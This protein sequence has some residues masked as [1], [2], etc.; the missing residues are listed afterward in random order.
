MIKNVLNNN[1]FSSLLLSGF[2]SVIGLSIL[3]ISLQIYFDIDKIITKDSGLINNDYLVIK[4]QISDLNILSKNA[5]SF[6]DQE[7]LELKECSFV[8]DLA[9]FRYCRY[10]VMAEFSS[11]S[12]NFPKFSTLIFFESIPNNFI[13]LDINNWLW[14]KNSKNVPIILPTTYVDAYNFGIAL[15][16]NAPQVSKNLLKAVPFK[17]KI[18]G[19]DKTTVYNGEVIGFSDRI[20]SVIVPDNFLNYTNKIYGSDKQIQTN[21]I[22]IATSN[23][24]DIAIRTYLEKHNYST[25]SEQIKEN[26]MLTILSGGLYYQLAICLIIVLQSLLLFIFYSNILISKSEYEIKLLLILGYT[27]TYI[28]KTINR[29]FIK[30]YLIIAVISFTLLFISKQII[31]HYVL[32][33]KDIALNWKINLF[34]I[35]IGVLFIISFILINSFLIKRKILIFAKNK[36]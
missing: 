17:I 18:I 11:N 29:V 22:I 9:T 32:N 28:S 35:I 26:K 23:A 20:N 15:S 7:I 13:D 14:D 5:S 36:K 24:K 16:M 31:N 30:T 8:N 4:K 12:L 10:Q 34:V 21:K 3:L 33:F 27:H 1:S 6:S 25:N 2:G 19:N